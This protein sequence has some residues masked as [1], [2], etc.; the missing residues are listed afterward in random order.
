MIG[1]LYEVVFDCPEPR[2]LADFYAE[3]TGLDVKYADDGW[4]TLGKGDDVRLAFQRAPGYQPPQWPDEGSS[5]QAHVDV[6]VADLDEAEQKV[7]ALGAKLLSA[8]EEEVRVYADPAGHPFCL[9]LDNPEA[10]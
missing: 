2:T 4:V 1:R 5:M 10:P 7:L 3:L 8:D 9:C 6:F